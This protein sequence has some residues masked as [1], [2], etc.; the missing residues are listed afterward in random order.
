MED[1]FDFATDVYVDKHGRYFFDEKTVSKDKL[2]FTVMV[3]LEIMEELYQ[4]L[5]ELI[6][7]PAVVK[8]YLNKVGRTSVQMLKH[9]CSL[10]G[11]SY[12]TDLIIK[13]LQFRRKIR[14]NC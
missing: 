12:H 10:E 5:S 2:A 9:L 7:Q 14:S 8:L 4:N 1:A 3:K 13:V 11:I 6:F